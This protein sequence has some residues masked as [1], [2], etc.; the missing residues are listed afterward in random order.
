[1]KVDPFFTVVIPTYN[2]ASFIE[3]SIQSV[4]KQNFQDFEIIVVD[5]GSTDNTEEVVSA[6][7][8]DKVIYH[9]KVNEERAVARNTGAKLGRGKYV[10]Y[11]DSD[12]LLYPNHLEEAYKL[13]QQYK[14]PEFFHLGYDIKDPKGKILSVVNSLSG[15]LNDKLIKGNFLSC[16]GV[17]LRRDVALQHPFNTDRDLSASEDYEL[18]LRLAAIYPLRFSNVITSTV[19][20]HELRSV[21][22]INKDKLIRRKSL[23]MKYLWEDEAVRNKYSKYKDLVLADGYT[24]TAL[25]LALTKKH[26]SSAMWYLV[27]SIFVRPATLSTRRFWATL[28]NII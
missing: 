17:F 18:W 7:N 25:H 6:I 10:N 27:K 2:R 12:D 16:N 24:Y 22:V 4:L 20:N 8:S 19:V 23:F 3:K 5:D 26:R 1:M 13:I 14:D 21:L 28:K 15:T 9:K 11:F